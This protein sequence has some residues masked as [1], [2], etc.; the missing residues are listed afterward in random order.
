MKI[1]V[2]VVFDFVDDFF[3]LVWRE[4]TCVQRRLRFIFRFASFSFYLSCSFCARSGYYR[5]DDF[6]FSFPEEVLSAGVSAGAGFFLGARSW[7]AFSVT[8]VALDSSVVGATV[9]EPP[10]LLFDLLFTGL[11]AFSSSFSGTLS[12]QP[13][14][15]LLDS[16]ESFEQFLQLLELE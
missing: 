6:H 4:V 13:P 8:T 1:R 5:C 15:L 12:L 3:E 2:A 10:G 7:A 14:R 11:S 16:P 9:W